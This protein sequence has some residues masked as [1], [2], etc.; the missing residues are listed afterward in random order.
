MGNSQGTAASQNL[1]M[2]GTFNKLNNSLKINQRK[3]NKNA[4]V[5]SSTHLEPYSQEIIENELKIP[6]GSAMQS[7][8]EEKSMKSGRSNA[9]GVGI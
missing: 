7:E 2:S 8:S 3:V 1:N 6:L 5:A 9:K 4:S